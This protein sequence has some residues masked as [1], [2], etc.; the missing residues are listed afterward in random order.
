MCFEKCIPVNASCKFLH[1][2]A[3]NRFITP[4]QSGTQENYR[5]NLELS[6][7]SLCGER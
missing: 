3:Q 6:K 2:E 1:S 5:E 7:L 4:K